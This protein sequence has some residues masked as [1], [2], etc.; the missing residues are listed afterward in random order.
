LIE[1]TNNCAVNYVSYWENAPNQMMPAYVALALTS[2]KRVLGD[3]FTLLTPSTIRNLVDPNVLDRVWA[4]NP[5]PFKLADGIE[6]IVAKSD[7]IRLAII[8]RYGGVWVDADTVFFRN[9][10]DVL[11]PN[12]L[13]KKL[14][15]HSE[16]VFGSKPGNELLRDALTNGFNNSTHAWGNPGKIK[17]IVQEAGDVIVERIA[18]D[19]FDPGFEPCYNFA[20]CEVMLRK[21]LDI[22]NF[23]LSN[24]ALIKLYN[25][26]FRRTVKQAESV[27]EFLESQILLAKIFL[28]INPD[29]N[30]WIE[31]CQKLLNGVS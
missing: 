29:K 14:H 5:L 22:E 30:Y 26:Y 24:V 28:H 4:F 1:K 20:S 23:L 13:S 19:V 6:A 8:E 7:F 31:E 9:P 2:I 12:G 27:E 18:S 21:D 11:F 10:S 3:R 16:C 17:E 25:T 15:W